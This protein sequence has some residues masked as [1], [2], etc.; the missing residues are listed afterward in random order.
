VLIAFVSPVVAQSKGAIPKWIN[1]Q[2]V[3]PEGAELPRYQSDAETE[4]LRAHPEVAAQPRAVTP[5]PTGPVQ[6]VAEYEPMDGLLFAWEQFNSPSTAILPTMIK[7]I[8]T[9]GNGKAYVVVDSAGEQ[10]TANTSLTTAGANLA[11]VQY[12]VTTTD[13]VWIRDYGPRYIFQGMCR[14][15]VDHDYNRPARPNDDAFSAVFSTVKKHAYY[16]H[17]LVHGGGNYHLDAVDRAYATELIWNENPGLTQTQVHDIWEDYQYVDTHIF[18]PFPVSVDSTQHLDMWMQI[19]DDNKVIIGD[20]PYNVGSTQDVICDNAA[21]YMAG[22]GYTVYRTISRS[23]GGTHYTFTNMVMFN[24]IV[25]LPTYTNTGITS[26]PNPPPSGGGTWNLNTEA[27]NV[28][29]AALPGK[30]IIQVNCEAMVSFAGVMHCI[31]MHVPKHAGAAGGFGGLAPTAYLKN[32]RGGEVL[33]PGNN[34]NIEWI[35]DD[36]V[37]VSNVDVLVSTNGGGHY[38]PIASATADDGTHTW[39][40]PNI[41]TPNARVKIVSRDGPGNTG[42]DASPAN[43]TINGTPLLGDLNCDGFFNASDADAFAQALV[44]QTLSPGCNL[45]QADLNGDTKVDGNDVPFF[46]SMVGL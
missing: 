16:E 40:V 44:H 4:F 9:T 7:H 39:T 32:L 5:P 2:W 13:S 41:Y 20:W 27:L 45:S 22:Q 17:Q 43:F 34:V 18:P 8:T 10:T 6:C 24:N 1:G 23:I 21:L 30:T 3:Y 38:N 25:L 35:T 42:F 37:S 36:D 14:A 19:I 26:A 31:V 29:A 28:V 15:I 11:N 46:L 33:T 12:V